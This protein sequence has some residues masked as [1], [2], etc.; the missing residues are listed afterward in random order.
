METLKLFEGN[1]YLFNDGSLGIYI[2]DIYNRPNEI[3]IAEIKDNSDNILNYIDIGLT[4]KAVCKNSFK[5]VDRSSIKQALYYKK[6][7]IK[8]TYPQYIELS[9]NLIMDLYSDTNKTCVN[10]STSRNMKEYKKTEDIIKTIIYHKEYLSMKFFHTK[11]KTIRRNCL[12]YANLGGSIG[13]E[14]DKIR[15]V[16]IWHTHNSTL[17]VSQCS[18]YVFPLTSKTKGCKYYFNVP[19]TINGSL[20]LIKINDGRRISIDRIIDPVFD[21]KTKKIIKL[22]DN[23]ISNI[24]DAIHDYFI[25]ESTNKKNLQPQI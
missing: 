22:S 16:V 24:N 2:C 3:Y 13:C 9:N 1:A 12:Y 25:Q 10:F 23:D 20:N 8:V 15:P 18:Y 21:N 4:N 6:K 5:I 7:L 11:M 17:D 14:T 19:I